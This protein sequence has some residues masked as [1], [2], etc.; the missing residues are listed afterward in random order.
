M[1]SARRETLVE[2]STGPL[3]R[4]ADWPNPAVLN[5]S[6]GVYTVWHGKQL[7]YVGISGSAV[8]ATAEDGR[9][10]VAGRLRG[11]RSRLDA[12]ASG[13]RSGDQFCVYVF[14][15][16]VLPTLGREQIEDAALGR[17]SLDGLTRKLIRDSLSYRFSLVAD[18]ET[19][20]TI[21]RQIQ[22]EGLEGQ[23]PVLNPS[24]RKDR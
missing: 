18:V 14:D 20:R 19:A 16:L 24:R 6:I 23:L 15:R 10:V 11:L 17:L 12:H 7:I 13:R 22:R 8:N 3:Y 4:F 5:R 1:T 2:L 21:E 9:G